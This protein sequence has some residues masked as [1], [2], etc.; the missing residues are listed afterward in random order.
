MDADLPPDHLPPHLAHLS[1]EG[2]VIHGVE[3]ILPPL[4]IV[5]AGPFLM[6]TDT[7][8]DAV[9]EKERWTKP[10]TP[11][12]SVTLPTYKIAR[13]PVTVAEYACFVRTGQPTPDQWETQ[14]SNLD[15][16]VGNVTWHDAVAYASWLSKQTGDCFRLPTEADWE[17]AAR[18]TDGRLYPW[19]D[20]FDTS[21]CNTIESIIKAA[22]PIGNYPGGTS[23]YG[24]QDMAGNIW[25]WTSSLLTPY[26]Y[27]EADGREDAH[28]PGL[29]VLR[30]G[31]WFNEAWYARAAYRNSYYPEYI[32]DDVG[33]R[34]V[35]VVPMS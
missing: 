5:P 8:R 25:E 4:C 14:L 3:V 21:R 7:A 1:F 24:V 33:F 34:L 9:T 17:K 20:S 2:R 26:P 22:T 28:A 35:R 10:E 11:Q 18:G 15:Y 27:Q 32:Y 29:R 23:F 31:S 6:G 30:G 12:H 16:P 19:G 13:Y